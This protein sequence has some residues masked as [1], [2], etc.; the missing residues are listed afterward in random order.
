MKRN[1]EEE[2]EEEGM[3]YYTHKKLLVFLSQTNNELDPRLPVHSVLDLN[4]R[5]SIENP[6]F[7]HIFS[8]WPASSSP[9]TSSTR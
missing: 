5:V 4:I 1:R 9:P 3:L 7:D 6:N 8:S 2:E